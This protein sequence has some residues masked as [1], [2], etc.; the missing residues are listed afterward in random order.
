VN[1]PREERLVLSLTGGGGR[2]RNGIGTRNLEDGAN[3]TPFRFRYLRK[4]K[5]RIRTSATAAS[6]PQT[7]PATLIFLDAL[8]SATGEGVGSEAIGFETTLPFLMRRK[9]RT[10]GVEALLL[11]S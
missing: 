10:K 5:A 1:R 11:L 4:K 3:F 6:N 9:S 2:W 7:T 8:V